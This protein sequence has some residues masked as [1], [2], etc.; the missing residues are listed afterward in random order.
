MTVPI[1][2]IARVRGAVTGGNPGAQIHGLVV[3]EARPR[4]EISGTVSRTLVDSW[5]A[6]SLFFRYRVKVDGEWIPDDELEGALT[7]E[8]KDIDSFTSGWTFTLRGPRWS[9]FRTTKVW[10]L[11]PVEVY[12]DHGRAGAVVEPETPDYAGYVIGCDQ[13]S[14][15]EPV[16]T[17]RCGGAA[18]AYS[19]FETCYESEPMADLTR[20][21]HLQLM[22]GE[23]GATIDTPAGAV[24]H[25]PLQAVNKKLFSIAL[26]LIEPEGWRIRER[27]D[28]TFEVW[29]PEIKR[30]PLPPDWE[31][32]AADVVS[33]SAVPPEAVPSRYVVTGTAV[34]LTDE[35]GVSRELTRTQ[36]TA[37][38]APLVATQVQ[39]GAGVLSPS[40]YSP[41]SAV[42]RL[43]S[44]IEEETLKRGGVETQKTERE[45]GWHNPR[46]G[47]LVS[48]GGSGGTAGG[49]YDYVAGFVDENG[50]HVRYHM[51]RFV[52]L[53]ERVTTSG[54]NA[55][56]DLVSQRVVT[57]R[58]GSRK[59]AVRAAGSADTATSVIGTYVYSDDQ[60][61]FTLYEEFGIQEESQI[62]FQFPVQGALQG[63]TQD[64]YAWHRPRSRRDGDGGGVYFELYDGTG[65]RGIVGNWE[66]VRRTVKSNILRNGQ[67]VGEREVLYTWSVA[68]RVGGTYD[69]GD[70][71]SDAGEE[72]FRFVRQEAKAFN[73]ISE[74][75]LEEVTYPATGG[76]TARTILGRLPITLY[77][78]STWTRLVS[79]PLEVVVDDPT[80]ATWF[81]FCRETINSEF[82][83]TAD[84]ARR[85]I[86]QR[87]RRLL[88]PKLE[89][90]RPDGPARKGDTVH[91]SC[92]EDG[93]NR[94]FII[95]DRRAVHAPGKMPMATY[96]LEAW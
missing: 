64:D 92:P 19:R 69:W 9:L 47:R 20:G 94:R 6:P 51:E 90:V 31:W 22:F 41:V 71:R 32:T 60:G 49:G 27:P 67:V 35:L 17:V 55:N 7:V 5:E 8:D 34:V 15:Y 36:L 84:E 39:D 86:E 25:K 14:T 1:A 81:G 24:Y 33:K 89:V 28:L 96:R 79:Q 93:I 23:A 56:A 16:V 26:A 48:T 62:T 61:Y 46:R 78:S 3:N 4:T 77:T 29:T 53:G 73:V 95:A 80:V 75:Q 52:L 40:G 83:Q 59:A 12:I 91:F 88:S 42:P 63:T 50:D 87:R 57:S 70:F 54:R 66:R 30:A 13:A 43:V 72:S 82:V 37:E 10:A 74:E 68:K 18:A 76:R 21:Q 45:Y 85:L 44:V 65:Q 58:F 2:A 11:T 38:Y